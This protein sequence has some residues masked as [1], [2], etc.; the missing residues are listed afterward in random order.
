VTRTALRTV[1]VQSKVIYLVPFAQ[2]QQQQQ[3]QQQVQ[4]LS[5]SKGQKNKSN[6]D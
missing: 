5:I 3:Q 1:V 4:N 6:L 2:Q